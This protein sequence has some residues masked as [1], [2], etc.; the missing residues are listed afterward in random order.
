[1]SIP[2]SFISIKEMLRDDTNQSFKQY[3]LEPNLNV[4]VIPQ[5][6]N[7]H[8]TALQIF[9][10]TIQLKTNSANDGL[11]WIDF[12]NPGSLITDITNNMIIPIANYGD[13]ISTN[14]RLITG[15]VELYTTAGALN[16]KGTLYIT[17][18]H[19]NKPALP[20]EQY[21]NDVMTAGETTVVPNSWIN[22]YTMRIYPTYKDAYSVSQFSDASSN[23]PS[24]SP[25]NT[26]AIAWNDVTPIESTD[27][28]C[29]VEY[30]VLVDRRWQDYRDVLGLTKNGHFLSQNLLDILLTDYKVT[31]QPTGDTLPNSPYY[32][33]YNAIYEV[34]I[35][36]INAG[37]Q[38][39]T[40]LPNDL[41]R[42]ILSNDQIVRFMGRH[43]ILSKDETTGHFSIAKPTDLKTLNS[44][45]TS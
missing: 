18:S 31:H 9:N 5:G 27:I 13:M 40:N 34:V 19:N 7:F 41:A 4:P 44:G 12:N 22:K 17:N 6:G 29:P 24:L 32:L 30:A 23:T 28:S 35:E 43:S 2:D 3:M 21:I 45:V 39:S 15:Y 8:G 1:M 36:G 33:K 25:R 38:S 11:Y 16:T 20:V 10:G 37:V 42:T 26:I 14:R